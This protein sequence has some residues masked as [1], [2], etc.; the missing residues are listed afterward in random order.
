MEASDSWKEKVSRFAELA[1]IDYAA[2]SERLSRIVGDPVDDGLALLASAEDAPDAMVRE[3]FP[4][5]PAAKLNRAIRHLRSGAG[6]ADTGG[7]APAAS[8]VLPRPPDDESFLDA[9]KVGGIAKIGPTD[10]NAALRA[11]LAHNLGLYELPEKLLAAM[12]EHADSLE[13]PVGEAF[14]ELQ[15][16]VLERRYGDILASLG[17]PGRLVSEQRKRRLF[18]RMGGIWQSLHG[19]QGRLDAWLDSWTAKMNN[20]AALM[21]SMAAVFG[22]G[23]AAPATLMEHPDVGPVRD[24]AEGVIDAVNRIFS[25]TGIPVARALAYDALRT[26]RL[27][28]DPRLPE[29]LGTSSREEM[30]KKLGVGVTADYVRL[31]RDVATYV[32]SIFELPRVPRSNEPGYLVALRELGAAIPWEKLGVESPAGGGRKGGR[33]PF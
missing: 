29:A 15:K 2:A 24:A 16:V 13:E 4:E 32:L 20:P 27:L 30:L 23:S 21:T 18:E 19:F 8:V 7:A 31:E 25:G 10:V 14:Y 1:G 26:K 3:L 28:E 11:L 6:A 22:G 17:I 33:Q 12:E 5:V 9:L